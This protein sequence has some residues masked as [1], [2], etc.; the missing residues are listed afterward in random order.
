VV[1][2][3]TSFPDVITTRLTLDEY[4]AMEKTNPERDE[5]R[6]REIMTLH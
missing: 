2:A 6:N 3:E 1:F 4:L 5:Y